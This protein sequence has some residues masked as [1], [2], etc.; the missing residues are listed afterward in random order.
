MNFKY[1]GRHKSAHTIHEN[2]VNVNVSIC[3]IGV[4]VGMYR[5]IVSELM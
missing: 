2:A 3:Y 5:L 4:N 1:K